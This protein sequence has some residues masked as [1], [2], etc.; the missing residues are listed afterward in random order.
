[1]KYAGRALSWTTT[2]GSILTGFIGMFAVWSQSWDENFGFD[3]EVHSMNWPLFIT[4]SGVLFTA[5]TYVV[6]S[7]LP[8]DADFEEGCDE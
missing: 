6:Y 1:M 8:Q 5:I 7:F 3:T 4:F 2:I